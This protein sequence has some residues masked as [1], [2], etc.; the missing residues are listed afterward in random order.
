[1]GLVLGYMVA[2]LIRPP[3]IYHGPNSSD[4]KGKVFKDQENKYYKFVPQA[5]ICPL[6]MQHYVS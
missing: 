5:H 3:M 1:M 6:I 4:I 2:R